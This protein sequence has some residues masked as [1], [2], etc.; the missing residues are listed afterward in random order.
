L[1]GGFIHD[2]INSNFRSGPFD[3]ISVIGVCLLCDSVIPCQ[4]ADNEYCKLDG[5]AL[6]K[7]L[8]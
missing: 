4:A 7:M 6:V 2:A 3:M 5:L 8:Q 1:P